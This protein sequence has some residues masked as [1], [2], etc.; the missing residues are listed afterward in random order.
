MY[1]EEIEQWTKAHLLSHLPTMLAAKQAKY[2]DGIKMEMPKFI[3]LSTLV[4]GIM[5]VARDSLPQYA[6][7]CVSK[8]LASDGDSLWDF[9]YQ[10]SIT[11]VVGDTTAARAD[12]KCKRVAA[13]IE[14]FLNTHQFP[15]ATLPEATIL[16]VRWAAT[17][18]SG[19]LELVD[20]KSKVTTWISVAEIQ[21]AW[22][23]S[24]RG[25]SQHG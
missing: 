24:E 20:S 16:S 11:V 2:T 17:S 14:Q 10:G 25:P 23:V 7:D 6:I 22:K 21:L 1:Y 9:V 4:G 13:V 3:D 19:S 12:A 15:T 8:E 5:N 18:F